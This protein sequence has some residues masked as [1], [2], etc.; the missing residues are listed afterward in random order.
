EGGGMSE[1][2]GKPLRYLIGRDTGAGPIVETGYDATR[3]SGDIAAKYV[4]L[5]DEENTGR[6]GPYLPPDD[7]DSEYHEPA[8]DPD[9]AGFWR[10]LALQLD[11]AK[12][13]AFRYVEL[14]NLHTYAVDPAIRCFDK[15]REAGLQVFCKNPLLVDGD[16]PQLL[17]H[18]AVVLVI[19]EEDAGTGEGMDNLRKRGGKPTLPVRF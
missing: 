7:I 14:H 1:L 10:N 3:P 2:A 13:Q 17:A 8:P 18:S 12:Q 11:R 19:V 6:Y 5:R 9:G 15:V 4:N 16:R